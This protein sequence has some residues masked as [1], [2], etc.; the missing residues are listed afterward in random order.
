MIVQV[1]WRG[2]KERRDALNRTVNA[3][4]DN[5]AVLTIQ[6]LFRKHRAKQTLARMIKEDK[7]ARIIQHTMKRT[8][9]VKQ[10]IGATVLQKHF[11][12]AAVR[13]RFSAE[14]ELFKKTAKGKLAHEREIQRIEALKGT[15]EYEI[16]M[17]KANAKALAEKRQVEA[18][19]RDQAM[20]R[21]RQEKERLAAERRLISQRL[22]EQTRMK[23]ATETV[24]RR[25]RIKAEKKAAM[26][27]KTHLEDMRTLEIVRIH[28]AN[29]SHAH[30]VAKY[31]QL[32]LDRTPWTRTL[33][34][35]AAAV[36][37][38]ELTR[39]QHDS[40]ECANANGKKSASLRKSRRPKG[41]REERLAAL[42]KP[43][44]RFLLAKFDIEQPINA[45]DWHQPVH[46]MHLRKLKKPKSLPQLVVNK[47]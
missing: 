40:S 45:R 10:T 20:K 47:R 15:P 6:T 43:H 34:N 11:R 4:R 36:E 21:E 26:R 30:N 35:I 41:I 28:A 37:R 9:L 46:K 27:Q 22:A 16:M 25:D 32:K 14:I 2:Y 31:R 12:G 24:L 29:A 23:C 42:A 1:H 5:A 33:E 19:K 44:P 13:R 8:K 3:A 18:A 38:A 7:A 39:S 17:R